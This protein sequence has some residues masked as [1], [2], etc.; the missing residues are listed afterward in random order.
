MSLPEPQ[1]T[2]FLPFEVLTGEVLARVNTPLVSQQRNAKRIFQIAYDDKLHV[3]RAVQ[4]RT[5]G[6]DVS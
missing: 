4:L 3:T 5:H 1:P 6:Y 2:S